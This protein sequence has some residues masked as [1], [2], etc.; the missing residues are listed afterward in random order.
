MKL[1]SQMNTNIWSNILQERKSKLL[2]CVTQK[3]AGKIKRAL[4][5]RSRKCNIFPDYL[6]NK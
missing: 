3:Y 2:F 5:Q 4:C 6:W 1:D